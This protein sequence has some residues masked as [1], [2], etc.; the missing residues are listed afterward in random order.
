MTSKQS[1]A[2]FLWCRISFFLVISSFVAFGFASF[3]LAEVKHQKES[4]DAELAHFKVETEKRIDNLIEENNQLIYRLEQYENSEVLYGIQFIMSRNNKIDVKQARKIAESVVE[5]S[6]QFELDYKLVLAIIWQESRF[7]AEAKSNQQAHGLMQLIPDT[8][9]A[10]AKILKIETWD[11]TDVN[12]NI[13][14]GTAYLARLKKIYNGDVKLMLAAY[15]GGPVCAK[16][17]QRYINGEI[18]I[19]SLSTENVGYIR[20]I[21]NLYGKM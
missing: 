7:N 10:L 17:Y 2:E 8:Q 15:N 6:A 20:S 19:D 16:R 5:H 18:P 13:L 12:T 21:T 1:F 11:I 9:K 3:Y 4:V 14:F